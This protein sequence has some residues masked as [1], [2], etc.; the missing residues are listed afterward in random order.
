MAAGQEVSARILTIPNAISFLRLALVPSSPSSSSAAT[1]PG[2]SRSS[3]SPGLPTGS[4]VCSPV[5]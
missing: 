3:R 5:A 1:T 4:T 2:R